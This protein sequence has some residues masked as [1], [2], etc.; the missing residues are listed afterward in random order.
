MIMVEC[1]LDLRP[2]VT[3]LA[4]DF[5]SLTYGLGLG[6]VGCGIS[7]HL[8]LWLYHYMLST[9]QPGLGRALECLWSY[10]QTVGLS[11]GPKIA[12]IAKVLA[13][14]HQQ[15]QHLG[16]PLLAAKLNS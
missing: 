7:C 12:S 8:N 15:L 4:G 6:M 14:R 11:D 5:T 13:S 1:L 3:L 2:Q 10:L 9:H 16:W